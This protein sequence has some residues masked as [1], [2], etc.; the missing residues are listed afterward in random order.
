[1]V[2]TLPGRTP[3]QSTATIKPFDPEDPNA[4]LVSFGGEP[5]LQPTTPNFIQFPQYYGISQ[6]ELSRQPNIDPLI[7][8][9]APTLSQLND[10]I[11]M[12]EWH[13]NEKAKFAKRETAQAVTNAAIDFV[14]QTDPD[15][16]KQ[17]EEQGQQGFGEAFIEDPLL[18]VPF[19]GALVKGAQDLDVIT[20]MK[21]LDADDYKDFTPSTGVG[22]GGAMLPQASTAE[23]Q[24]EKDMVTLGDYWTNQAEMTV[25]GQSPAGKLASGISHAPAFMIE[26]ATTG[27]GANIAK[28]AISKSIARKTK[29][30]VGEA[31]SKGIG[32]VVGFGGGVT[33]RAALL[34]QRIAEAGASRNLQEIDARVTDKGVEIISSESPVKSLLIGG[35]ETL[36]STFAES[37]GPGI[38]ALGKGMVPIRVRSAFESLFKSKNPKKSLSSLWTKGG[39]DGFITENTEEELEKAMRVGFGIDSLEDYKKN[40][41]FENYLVQ[42]GVIGAIGGAKKTAE[43]GFRIADVV[44]PKPKRTIA[45]SEA[46]L[47]DS[48]DRVPISPVIK[49]DGNLDVKATSDVLPDIPKGKV[50]IFRAESPTV[51]F[52]DVFNRDDLK[53]FA[54]DREGS[55]WSRDLDLADF[56]RKKYGPDA[57][58][59]YVDLPKEDAGNFKVNGSNAEFVLSDS[60]FKKGAEPL[61]NEVTI[62]TPKKDIP[63]ETPKLSL[64]EAKKAQSDKE[65]PA[66]V[67]EVVA[68]KERPTVEEPKRKV[69]PTRADLKTVATQP[70]IVSGRPIRGAVQKSIK[71]KTVKRQVR[72]TT[73][74]VDLQAKK[75]I[76]EKSLVK[77]KFSSEQKGSLKGFRAAKLET[78]A[79]LKDAKAFVQKNLPLEVRGKALSA[80]K[81][82]TDQK[83][84]DKV[85]ATVNKLQDEFEH[86]EAKTALVKTIK[87]LSGTRA[88]RLLPEFRG[89][90]EDI[91]K[92]L[93]LKQ[94][95]EKVAKALRGKLQAIEDDPLNFDDKTINTTLDKLEGAGRKPIG[96][97]SL[98][99]LRELNEALQG[100]EKL[101]NLK[102]KLVFG[103]SARDVEEFKSS[104]I[105]SLKSQPSMK[106]KNKEGEPQRGKVSEILGE[107]TLGPIE[108]S[109]RID[110]DDT[111][112]FKT[113]FYDNPKR[114]ED[115]YLNAN[116]EGQA[117]VE[118]AAKAA[119]MEW[120]SKALQKY[121]K[122][123]SDK[124]KA[125]EVTV[126]LESG[127][128]LIVSPAELIGLN[129]MLGDPYQQAKVINN[130]L[131]F[132]KFDITGPEHK[133]TRRD[134]ETIKEAMTPEYKTFADAMG[135]WYNVDGKALL[136]GTLKQLGQ[137]RKLRPNYYPITVSKNKTQEYKNLQPEGFI[138]DLAGSSFLQ[139]TVEHRK[140]IVLRDAFIQFYEHV[141]QTAK[142]RYIMMPVRN[143]LR[144]MGDPDVKRE[145]TRVGGTTAVEYWNNR[146]RSIVQMGPSRSASTDKIYNK[147]LKGFGTSALG[148]NPSP[149]LKQFGGLYPAA[150][151]VGPKV[152]TNYAKSLKG[153][154]KIVEEFTQGSPALKDRYLMHGSH[155]TTQNLNDIRPLLGRQTITDK[156]LDGLQFTDRLV[157]SAIYRTVKDKVRTN[158]PKMSEKDLIEKAARETE[159]VVAQT[160]NIT[161][162]LDMSKLALDSKSSAILKT[163]TMF[164]S[165]AE[166]MQ[167]MIR[168]S[169]WRYRKSD[170]TVADT[171]KFVNT[172]ASVMIGNAGH[173]VVTGKLL[174]VA[175]AAGLGLA[176]S[177]SDDDLE[178]LISPEELY[179]SLPKE[180]ILENLGSL[181]FIG[182]LSKMLDD[183]FSDKFWWRTSLS[184]PVGDITTDA[185]D[186]ALNA[187][188]A[189]EEGFSSARGTKL[190]SNAVFDAANVAFVLRG[191]P[192]YPLR[193]AKKGLNRLLEETKTG[194]SRS[195]RRRTRTRPQT[196][197]R[198]RRRQ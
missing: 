99:R 81:D 146:T 58:L 88:N 154:A 194:S 36:I 172:L 110:N 84:L 29:G 197:R 145:L 128:D 22:M 157:V 60:I 89:K 134:V 153:N 91:T 143:M 173:S 183:A 50:R 169:V 161:S 77:L 94:T 25:R 76:S 35:A 160:Q 165:N 62:E 30:L 120:G 41:T 12:V 184:G 93:S 181:Y 108:T 6:E 14:Q 49:E 185:I 87:G 114:Q 137:S 125:T 115:K 72:E 147:I 195:T 103:K 8:N 90:V 57:E 45:E 180:I 55:F 26:F 79:N 67:E 109:Q 119:G 171:K 116:H 144:I 182:E 51:K 37:A 24:R 193:V 140:Q 86:R 132:E 33:T 61:E 176:I 52:D 148:W 163:T 179:Q 129:L 121:S 117:V 141:D 111:G 177:G 127:K 130:G 56:F 159:L 100:I 139:N 5:T 28:T 4:G 10:P 80:L 53:D 17:W 83:G 105:K 59:S 126:K 2:L 190:A 46:A 97:L 34:P 155:L 118:D 122:H 152:F 15:L 187:S 39:F 170:K 3:T 64:A 43:T 44:L 168:Q 186:A 133:I 123:T 20:S 101:N 158:N 198:R 113:I 27:G 75:E 192:T 18:K 71:P 98:E 70:S 69:R 175:L 189:T 16:M 131:V 32:N 54:P 104:I 162:V 63:A 191:I 19:A 74:Q 149:A 135:K 150:S 1:M 174:K 96:D 7:I 196:R 38:K 151:I 166:R 47:S 106:R 138:K 92:D 136:D 9:D 73:G 112:A 178:K 65:V 68:E 167:N 188:K 124:G 85:I 48:L 11:A 164:K 107:S 23:E 78:K 66:V 142:A 82:A 40:A 156:S 102:N 31:V 21:R 42:A 13:K 95:S